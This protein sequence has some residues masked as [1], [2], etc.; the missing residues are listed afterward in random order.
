MWDCKALILTF[1]LKR[2]IDN[3]SVQNLIALV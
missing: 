3:Q 2:P 1:L